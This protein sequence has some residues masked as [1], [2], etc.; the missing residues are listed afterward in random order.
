MEFNKTGTLLATASKKGTLIKI[1]K[2]EEKS[3]IILRRGS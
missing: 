1:L 3:I 2:V